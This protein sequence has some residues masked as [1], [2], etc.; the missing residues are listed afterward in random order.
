MSDKIYEYVLLSLNVFLGFDGYLWKSE[1]VQH[2]E[3]TM[4]HTDCQINSDYSPVLIHHQDIYDKKMK[5]GTKLEK[6]LL[7]YQHNIGLLLVILVGKINKFIGDFKKIKNKKV[8]LRKITLFLH[9]GFIIACFC[10]RCKNRSVINAIK[11][12]FSTNFICGILHLQLLFSHF[13]TEHHNNDNKN[14]IAQQIKHSINYTSKPHGFWHYFHVS[15]AHQIEHHVDPKIA[16][17]HQ[18]KI[19][20]DVKKL[21]DKYNLEYK[22]EDFISMLVNYRKCI[23]KISEN[24]RYKN[25]IK[26]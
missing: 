24:Y 23:K 12:I 19:T 15:L 9:Y 20:N 25:N 5:Y 26:I 13:T 14:D 16:S 10:N 3:Y 18:H 8:L 1:H 21:C 17:Q 4:H 7:P 2:H 6:I 11:F 22:S